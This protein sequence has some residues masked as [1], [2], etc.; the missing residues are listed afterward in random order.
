LEIL[1]LPPSLKRWRTRRSAFGAEAGRPRGSL[2]R[3]ARTVATSGRFMRWLPA[4]A[5]VAEVHRRAGRIRAEPVVRQPNSSKRDHRQQRLDGREL[6]RCHSFSAH[7]AGSRPW[8]CDGWITITVHHSQ[9]SSR[10]HRSRLTRAPRF[11]L[12]SPA[13]RIPIHRR[14]AASTISCRTSVGTGKL[15]HIGRG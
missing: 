12:S 1:A 6:N 9:P 4:I 11:R 2:A 5:G 8:F 14:W 7:L 3:L 15:S 13:A 10:H